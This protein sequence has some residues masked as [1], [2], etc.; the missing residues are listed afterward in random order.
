MKKLSLVNEVDLDKSKR[1]KESKEKERSTISENELF[2]KN[3]DKSIVNPWDLDKEENKEVKT[4]GKKRVSS[5]QGK[6]INQ[7]R[8]A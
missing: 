6:A 3:I 8:K 1:L 7:Y 5:H 2:D 4:S